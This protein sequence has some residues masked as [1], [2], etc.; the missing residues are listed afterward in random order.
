MC[1]THATCR[2]WPSCHEFSWTCSRP[3]TA[4]TQMLLTFMGGAAPPPAGV[5]TGCCWRP[6]MAMSRSAVVPPPGTVPRRPPPGSGPAPV[7]A[8]F[9]MVVKNYFGCLH[10]YAVAAVACAG[11]QDTER[12]TAWAA[13]SRPANRRPGLP[14]CSRGT[15]P[16]VELQLHGHMH[17]CTCT[18][19][20]CKYGRQ[21]R[22]QGHTCSLC[23]A[24]AAAVHAPHTHPGRYAIACWSMSSGS[25]RAILARRPLRAQRG[26]PGG[27]TPAPP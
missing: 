2:A 24:Q 10:R 14:G 22:T 5:R 4:C 25:K 3:Q 16:C 19:G 7:L 18:G 1:V 27:C 11:A 26:L 21:T 15:Q 23:H 17:A 6:C 9:P 8:P 13:A 12:R 20:A